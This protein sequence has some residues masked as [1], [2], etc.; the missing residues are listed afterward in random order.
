MYDFSPDAVLM[1]LASK[2]YDESDHIKDHDE[3]LRSVN[4]NGGKIA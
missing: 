1:I 4:G 3:F 2:T